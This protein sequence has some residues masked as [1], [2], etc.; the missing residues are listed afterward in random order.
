MGRY[1]D[2]EK[3]TVKMVNMFTINQDSMT[4]LWPQS[5]QTEVKKSYT[6]TRM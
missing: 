3:T 5:V 6:C 1:R 2:T 4:Y